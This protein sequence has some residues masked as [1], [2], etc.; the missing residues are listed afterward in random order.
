M[1]KLLLIANLWRFLKVRK[2][3]WLSPIVMFLILIGLML[4]MPDD[5]VVRSEEM[6]RPSKPQGRMKFPPEAI[7]TC[8]G[9]SEGTSVQFTTSHGDTLK[10]VCKL[11]EGVLTAMPEPGTPPPKSNKP[12]ESK[13]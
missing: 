10:G 5:S 11:F 13:S 12:T 9:K 1:N 4:I 3:W 6:N 8:K 7:E 2:K